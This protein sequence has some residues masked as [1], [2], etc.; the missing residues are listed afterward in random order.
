MEHCDS[1][2]S[3]NTRVAAA[4]DAGATKW[5]FLFGSTLCEGLL[6]PLMPGLLRGCLLLLL[7]HATARAVLLPLCNAWNCVGHVGLPPPLM[8][9][10]LA[11]GVPAEMSRW[12]V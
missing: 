2:S 5:L 4:A 7:A 6:L 12:L 1:L 9:V 8:P 3:P 10:L 11:Q